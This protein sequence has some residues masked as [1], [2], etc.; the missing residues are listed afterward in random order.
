MT[1]ATSTLI[2]ALAG[3]AVFALAGFTLLGRQPSIEE[4][5]FSGIAIALIYWGITVAQRRRTRKRL[6][7]IRD[8]ALW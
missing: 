1:S 6:D 3:V 2:V 4:V 7:S 8:S 5:I